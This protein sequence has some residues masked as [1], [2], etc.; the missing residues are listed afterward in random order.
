VFSNRCVIINGLSPARIRQST[1][2]SDSP[3]CL[4]D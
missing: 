2:T 3:Q 1:L 4:P